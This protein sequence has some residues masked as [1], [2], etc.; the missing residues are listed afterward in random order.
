MSVTTNT[1]FDRLIQALKEMGPEA[2]E[3]VSE[4]DLYKSFIAAFPL[5]RLPT[6]SIDD[7]C[8]GTGKPQS[9]CWWIERGLEPVMGRYMPGTSRGHIVYWDQENNRLYKHRNLTDLPD[10]DALAY[11]L[12]VQH[13]IA[14]ARLDDLTWL[15][16]DA[17]IY[18]R[19]GV[20]PRVTAG[21]GRKL[22][23]LACYHPE[24]VM[25]I[26]SA[27][28]VVHFLRALG[29]PE[30]SIPTKKQAVAGMLAL[31]EYFLLARESVPGLSTRGFMKGLYRGDVELTPPKRKEDWD[32]EDDDVAAPAYLLT[33]NPEQVRL[34]GD[35]GVI[36]GEERRWTC[37]STRPVPGDSIYLVRLGQEPRGIV[38]RGTVTRA[39]E[40]GAHWRDP[41]K[42]A[43]Y[44]HFRVEEFRPTAASGMVPMVLLKAAMPKQQWSPQSSGIAIPEPA[45]GTL[46]GMWDAGEGIHSLRQFVNWQTMSRK[47]EK[48]LSSY[49]RTTDHARSLRN[50]PSDL[51]AEA[52]RPLWSVRD[53]GVSNVGAGA[54]SRE[55]FGANQPLLAELTRNILA[56]PDA[57]TFRSVVARW[58][59]AVDSNAM[60]KGNWA[61]IR[62]VFAAADPEAFTTILQP[63]DCQ[64]VLGVLRQQFE[65]SPSPISETDWPA[66]NASIRE[67]M[68]QAALDPQRPLE[69]NVAMWELVNDSAAVPSDSEKFAVRE[70]AAAGYGGQAGRVTALT[71]ARNVVLY[72]PPGTGK[73]FATIQHAV[74]IVAPELLEGEIE[75]DALKA[76]FDEFIES[77]QIVFT[78]F[79]QSYSYEDFVEGIRASSKN[80]ALEYSVEPG[81]FKRLCDRASQGRV[82]ADDPFDR[83]L[84]DLRAKVEEAPNGRVKMATSR[85][86]PFEASFD[87][88]ETFRV[89]PA[90]S[91]VGSSGYT[92]SMRQVRELFQHGD[93]SGM[94]NASYVRGMLTFLQ[95]HCGL[96]TV[97]AAAEAGPPKP[98]VM[99]IDEINRGS[100]SRIFGELITLIEPSKRAGMPE[101][102]SATL[103]Y[104]KL[105]F[106]VPS[107]LH[108]IAT[109]NTAD[110]SLTG[111][112]IA[113][114]RRFEFVEMQPKPEELDAVYID[115]KL[116]VGE[117]L[118]VMNQRIELVLDRDHCLGH[119]MFM[120]LKKDRTLA[121]L[122]SVFKNGVLPLLQEYF[123]EDWQRIQWVLN[124]HRKPESLQFVRKPG[125]DLAKLFGEGVAVNEQ[126]RR[127][128]INDGAFDN[129]EAF[130]AIIGMQKIEA[131]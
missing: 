54:L 16:D 73:T 92:A 58:Q 83:A 62:R 63:S 119:A 21:K 67:C 2:Q 18:K 100:V 130:A 8:V 115:E 20:E 69:N 15:D 26:S 57:D 126:S 66:L 81:V 4:T 9:F 42:T 33:W 11:T 36:V 116:S 43:R 91:D 82:A 48:W 37:N 24:D 108:I 6:L 27:D 51:D 97:G 79:H 101:A 111:L 40:E 87:G 128:E 114:R 70:P 98:F 68:R 49:R 129:V 86:K 78:T 14:S 1:T 125:T 72:G 85:G 23:L 44:I 105:P 13:A 106:S 120:P 28:H 127:W 88:G 31:R 53:N 3:R 110:R 17:A 56:K 123:F 38:A 99:I 71:E 75:R 77:G 109:M 113:L 103:P 34:G 80:G 117:L 118:R 45:A 84:L 41:S 74:A 59:S 124:D 55:D 22:R 61:V 39:S 25:L 131:A 93:D 102:L 64:K 46:R 7:Y 35:E 29:T 96:P 60:S 50:N 32:D 47:A 112:D 89:F 30:A 76:R 107:N 121:R 95:Q 5:D 104:S 19:V 10:A 52:L 90:S 65:L 12:K 122:A 94:Y